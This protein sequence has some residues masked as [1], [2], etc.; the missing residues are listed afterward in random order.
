MRPKN[1]AD[2]RSILWVALAAGI[3]ILQY[4]WPQTVFYALPFSCYLGIACGVITHNHSHRPTFA[5]RWSNNAFGHVLTFFYGYPTLMWLPTHNMNH[6]RFVNRRGDATITWRYTNRHNLFV[7]LSYFFVSAWFQS[8]PIQRYIRRAKLTNRHLYG[9]ILVQYGL[10]IAYIAV[11]LTLA[12]ALHPLRTGLRV[13][14]FATFLPAFASLFLIMFFNYT[15]H[16]HTD[17]FSEHDHSRN[18]TG[19]IFNFL[20]FNNGYH[21]AHH[22]RPGLHWSEL[23]AAHAL[24]A[25][26]IAPQL[27]EPNLVWYLFRQYVLALVS[28]GRAT[29]QLGPE[30]GATPA[31]ATPDSGEANP[32]AA[33]DATAHDTRVLVQHAECDGTIAASV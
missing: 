14:I 12:L 16:V 15:Q 1:P 24:I 32:A 30:P 29:R 7:A 19:G 9:R 2:Y 18:F 11:T 20:F 26:A 3:A 28:P 13:W 17:A 6:H 8:E 31:C 33:G 27:N 5:K 21:T 10:W 25:G 4:A 23:P 22:N